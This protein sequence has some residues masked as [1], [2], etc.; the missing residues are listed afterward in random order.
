MR[1]A[2]L[3][4]INDHIRDQRKHS[5]VMP[6]LSIAQKYALAKLIGCLEGLASSGVFPED[7]EL[8]I[9]AVVADALAAFHLPSMEETI[10]RVQ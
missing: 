2:T 4:E 10:G 7:I 1:R 8:E 5:D 3:D 6:D 9:R